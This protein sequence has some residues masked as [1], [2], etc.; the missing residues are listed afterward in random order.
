MNTLVRL[1]PE[2]V[3]QALTSAYFRF[4]A[5]RAFGSGNHS[6]LKTCVDLKMKVHI[7]PA[8]QDNYMYLLIDESSNEAAVVDPVNP[9]KVIEMAN[10]ENV[11]LTTVL[12]THHHWDHAGGNEELVKLVPG[13]AVYGG[14]DRIGALNKKVSHGDKL[15][16]GNLEIQCLFTP[17]HT[18]GHICYYLPPSSVNG[19]AAVFTGDTLFQGG[20]GRFFEGTADQMY[21]ALIDV[22]GGLPDDTR[23]YCGHEYSLQ[24]LAFG[25]H[26]EP[27]N[28]SVVKRISWA[29][30]QR[31]KSEPT[32]PS[33]LSEEKLFNPFMRVNELTVQRHAKQ[34]DPIET[35][36][37][38][39]T[40]KDSF[41]ANI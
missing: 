24:N 17:C 19:Q 4:S 37:I 6:Q 41:K 34:N 14:D 5:W 25:L 31:A 11:K 22:L 28:E 18:S 21:H 20:C 7:I 29:K 13:L 40:E 39:R 33:L 1:L 10:Q 9:S 27:N 2:S 30:E 23:V 32:V 15:Q 38:L 35:M 26:V 16:V 8:L 12:T 36:K 3:L